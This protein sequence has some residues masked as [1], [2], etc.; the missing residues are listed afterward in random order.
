[1]PPPCYVVVDAFV[2]HGSVVL[3]CHACMSELHTKKKI[4]SPFLDIVMVADSCD[5]LYADFVM[6]GLLNQQVGSI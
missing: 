6:T 3:P 1:M 4:T 2:F 5:D